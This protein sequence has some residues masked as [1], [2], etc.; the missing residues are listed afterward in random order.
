VG[1]PVT[2]AT[3]APGWLLG[4]LLIALPTG[5]TGQVT[6]LMRVYE[7]ATTADPAYQAAIAENRAAQEFTPQ[8]R[9]GLLPSISAQASSQG[10]RLKSRRANLSTGR[11]GTSTFNSHDYS[12]DLRQPIYRYDRWLAVDQAQVQVDRADATL[13]FERQDLMLRAAERYFDVLRAADRLTFAI[14]EMEAFG[15][16]L[17]QSR[18]R[19]EVGLIAITD[20]EEAKAGFDLA[21]AQVIQAENELDNAREALREVTGQYHDEIRPLGNQMP[22]ETPE[23][24]DID[25]WTETALDQNLQLIGQ[26]YQA[27]VARRQI[28]IE[29]SGHLPTMDLIASHGRAKSGGGSL[30]GRDDDTSVVGVEVNVPLFSGFS[31]VSRT[32]ESRH[33]YQQQLDETERVRRAVQRQTRNAF[34]GVRSG[35]SRVRALEQAVRS[36]ASAVEATEAGFQVGTRTTVDVLNAQRDL[37]GARRDYAESRYDYIVNILTLKQAAGTLEEGDLQLV[38]GW[39]E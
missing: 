22:L 1:R 35:I 16:Q 2:R 3:A 13:A 19:F 4:A 30:G 34:L 7:L 24:D 37:F 23:P 33:L 17:E 9:A 10:N 14:A 12:I 6:D 29:E 27:D 21:R 39:L 32:R 11:V 36:N 5:A 31:V 18:Q 25:R 28:G 26:R 20:V 38:N 8:A 15:Q